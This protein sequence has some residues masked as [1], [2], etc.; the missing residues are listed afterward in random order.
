MTVAERL[1]EWA[2]GSDRIPFEAAHAARRHLLDGIGCAL[3]ARGLGV[4]TPALA[5]AS[6]HGASVI[7]GGVADPRTAALANGNLI[8]ALE[9]DDIHAASLVHVTAAVAPATLASA[10][11]EYATWDEAV[12]AYVVG[13]EVV[14]R[15]GGAVTHGFHRRGFDVTSVVGVFGSVLAIARLRRL[16]PQTAT[17]AMGIAGSLAAGSLEF[18]ADG[19]PTKQLHP[20]I[21]AANAILSVDLAEAGA[22]GPSAILEGARGLFAAYVGEVVDVDALTDGLG[23][24]WEVERVAIKGYPLSQLSHATLDALADA[25][26]VAVDAIES[27]VVELPEDAIAVVG[28]PR[29]D[30]VRPRSGYEAKFSVQWDVAAHLIDG[31]VTVATFAGD[32]YRRAD[33]A[34]LADRVEVRGVP[35]TGPPASAPG[36]VIVTLA[37]GSIREGVAAASRGTPERPLSDEALLAKFAANVEAW[38]TDADA[39][40]TAVLSG[41]ASTSDTLATAGYAA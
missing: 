4:P 41:S 26:E 13:A 8:H 40:A 16:D 30:K 35:W 7:G 21:A 10:E 34:A 37:D 23:V 29:A 24:R 1:A 32:G 33:V 27:V 31:E 9:F 2:L 14:T 36:H 20:G 28:E 5:L 38:G 12:D 17:H 11:A 18:L 15:I 22:T 19:A 6:G 39:C 25:G 3:G